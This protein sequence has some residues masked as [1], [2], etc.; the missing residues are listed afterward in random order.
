MRQVCE[1][2]ISHF[3]YANE[4]VELRNNVNVSDGMAQYGWTCYDT[5]NG[6]R[7]IIQDVDNMIDITTDFIKSN[8][9]QNVGSWGLRVKGTPRSNAPRDLQTSVVFYIGME[10]MDSCSDC[11]LESREERGAGGD[12]P[13]YAINFDVSHPRLGKAGIHIPIPL[14]EDDQKGDPVVTAFNVSEDKLW[15]A[16]CKSKPSAILAIYFITL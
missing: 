15:Q 3:W 1:T 13:L 16:K 2:A 10:A 4:S 8:D 7:Q 12:T 6:G 9:G 14:T 11:K 5:R